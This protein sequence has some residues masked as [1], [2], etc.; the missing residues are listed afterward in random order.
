MVLRLLLKTSALFLAFN[1]AFLAGDP[2]PVVGR[3]S[4]YNLIFPGR[5]R[6][7]YGEDPAQAYNLSSFSL[8]A[9]FASHT[10]ARPKAAHEYR[11]ALVGDSSIWGFL[12]ENKDTLTAQL[13]AQG[14]T[15]P[16]G[17]ALRFYNLGYPI[18]SLTKDLLLLSRLKA[19][20]PDLVLWFITL[21]S[22]PADKQLFPPLVQN[23]AE[24]VRALIAKHQLRL[25]PHD[26]QLITP[27][28]WD[29]TLIGRRRALADVARLQLYGVL[30]AGTGIDQAIPTTYT[31]RA[32]DLDTDVRFHGLPPPAL[33]PEDLAL[34]VLAA[35][36]AEIAPTPVLLVN[37][38]MFISAGKNSELRYNF[39]YPRWAYDE[40]LTI[41]HAQS[42]ARH[43]PYLDAWQNAA[44][45]TEFTDSPI[46]L[47][48]TGEAQFAHSLAPM[49]NKMTG[50]NP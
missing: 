29:R 31:P 35:G 50:V 25:D 20:Q 39:F 7:P 37:E 18:L 9:L 38:P 22:F 41:M 48:P 10:I 27:S 8:E 42:T 49:I 17:R 33:T 32:E 36:L 47:T 24:A 34:D 12:L 13:N 2:L 23:N 44:A 30:W 28:W 11:V 15:A 21:E 19:Y 40:Y 3:M 1:L 4:A 26:P 16:D 45:N 43:W 46:H 14:L 6:L 5:E